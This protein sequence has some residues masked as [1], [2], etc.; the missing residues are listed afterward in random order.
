MY[1]LSMLIAKLHLDYLCRLKSDRAIR[2][3][4]LKLP[5]SIYEI[6]DDILEDLVAKYPDDIEDICQILQWLVG[7]L[8]PLTLNELSEAIS[9]RD[10]E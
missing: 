8:T 6:Y 3:G 7:S 5:T 10:E 4:L 9:I 2:E 1:R